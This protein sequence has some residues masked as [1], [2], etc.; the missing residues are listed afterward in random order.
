[1]N[2][3]CFITTEKNLTVTWTTDRANFDDPEEFD[4]IFHQNIDK[5]IFPDEVA[6]AVNADQK[7]KRAKM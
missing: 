4:R 6:A 3:F 5:F 7:A 2:C 1:M